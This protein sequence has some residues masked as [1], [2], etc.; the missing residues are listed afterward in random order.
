M[1]MRYLI[2]SIV[3][4]GMAVKEFRLAPLDGH[5]IP[6][7]Q[8]GAHVELSF[9]ARSGARYTNAYSIVGETNGMLRIAVQRERQGRGGSRSLHDEFAP[10]MVLDLSMPIEGF[11]L[12][13]GARRNVL[14]AGGIGIT[15]IV[16]MARVLH[17]ACL[18]FELHYL[19]RSPGRLALTDDLEHLDARSVRTYLTDIDGRPDLEQMIGRWRDGSALHACGPRTLLNAIRA[20]GAA[21]GWPAQHIHFES[22][23]ASAQPQDRP[24]RVHLRQSGISLDAAPGKSILDTMLEA[25]VFVSYD[26]KRGECGNCYA[27]VLSGAALHRDICLTPAQRAQGMT[28]CVSW[29]S[30]AELELD[31]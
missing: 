19:V 29:C 14:I 15:P 27:S 8:A 11:R 9:R 20:T 18:P 10:G 26:C 13:A 16:P 24:V 23:G 3:P 7:W 12:R 30:G 31:L 6:P 17:S 1:T 4:H 22:F 2:A 5:A 21:Q 25:G 28:P